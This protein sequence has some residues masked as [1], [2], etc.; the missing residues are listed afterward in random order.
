MQE[1]NLINMDTR[2]VI[3]GIPFEKSDIFDNQNIFL[4]SY[5]SKKSLFTFDE[6]IKFIIYTKSK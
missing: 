1:D 4:H 2:T 3:S 5:F 6:L